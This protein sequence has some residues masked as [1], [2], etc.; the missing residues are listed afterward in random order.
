MFRSMNVLK[1]LL[2]QLLELIVQWLFTPRKRD[3]TMAQ[4]AQ[5]AFNSRDYRLAAEMFEKC[6]KDL[7]PADSAVALDLQF[8]Y[9]DSLANC[10]RLRD[11]LAVYQCVYKRGCAPERL[12]HLAVAL[13]GAAQATAPP[14]H[15]I[16]VDP[17]AC[18]VCGNVLKQPVSWNCG[19]CACSPCDQKLPRDAHCPRFV[20]IADIL[21]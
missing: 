14:P 18:V 4:V 12:R 21:N 8:G 7:G 19:H 2:V 15:S 20:Y 10:G 5:D 13:V 17:L 16:T 9:A 6:V 1:V 3:A 11:A